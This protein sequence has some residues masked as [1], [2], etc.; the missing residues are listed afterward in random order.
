M[1]LPHLAG[2]HAYVLFSSVER[3]RRDGVRDEELE[4]EEPDGVD[5][6][7]LEEG[8]GR[9]CAREREDTRDV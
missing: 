5:M 3:W 6:G 2:E 9:R 1:I 4:A 7:R 8:G